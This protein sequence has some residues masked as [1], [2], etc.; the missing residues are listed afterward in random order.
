MSRVDQY[1][2]TARARLLAERVAGVRACRANRGSDDAA[3]DAR[4][5]EA[6]AAVD[7]VAGLRYM[8]TE[9]RAGA[10]LYKFRRTAKGK[11]QARVLVTY[12]GGI[13]KA[14]SVEG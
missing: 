12:G 9:Q 4:E 1:E 10:V 2:N 13:I 8:T 14:R 7:A 6:Q 11:I 3:E 5:A